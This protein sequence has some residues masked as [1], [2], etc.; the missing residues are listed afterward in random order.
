[1]AL[2]AFFPVY[3]SAK[4]FNCKPVE[5]S[6]RSVFLP[7]SKVIYICNPKVAGSSIIQSLLSIDPDA[8]ADIKAD[9]N[10]PSSRRRISSLRD[11]KGFLDCIEDKD[12]FRFAFVRN[13]YTRVMS[14][15][16]DKIASGR[17][18]RFRMQLGLPEN[19]EISLLE[20]LEK[21]SSQELASMNRH[22]RPQSAL[23]PERIK[24]S[25]LGR[26]ENLNADLEILY[27]KIG[28][29]RSDIKTVDYHRT[30]TG[31]NI[32]LGDKEVKL[33]NMIYREDF[34]RFNYETISN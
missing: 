10:S 22:W 1:M 12:A 19:G 4:I 16:R 21:V 3:R 7:D 32:D 20:F 29:E 28:V 8:D 23:I 26:F 31:N 33:I 5:L 9:H 24:L 34:S 18:P 15:F 13:P 25:F 11:P 6:L 17:A 27:Q 30:R 14:C 2:N